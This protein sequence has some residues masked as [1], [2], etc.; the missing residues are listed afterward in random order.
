MGNFAWETF[1][2]VLEIWREVILSSWILFK[3][4]TTI[5][6]YWTAIKIKIDMTCVYKE[7]EVK[8]IRTGAM[9]SVRND[10]FIEL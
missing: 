9:T 3:G 5:L 6:K 2:W 10:F 4:K 8:A 1:Y 7:E